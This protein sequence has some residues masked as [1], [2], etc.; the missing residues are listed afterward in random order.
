MIQA[1]QLVR[2]S[3]LICTVCA[4]TSGGLQADRSF[5]Q[6]H[7]VPH[8]DQKTIRVGSRVRLRH[9]RAGRSRKEWWTVKRVYFAGSKTEFL[10]SR[11][12][13]QPSMHE[14]CIEL[15]HSR[16]KKQVIN[17]TYT[18]FQVRRGTRRNYDLII[19]AGLG[20]RRR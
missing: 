3:I 9:F 12:S 19:S 16:W 2:G 8:S 11:H 4:E 1:V 13:A 7:A 14:L 15:R 10:F 6:I 20:R 5:K 17:L 18:A